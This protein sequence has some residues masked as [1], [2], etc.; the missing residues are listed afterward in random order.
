MFFFFFLANPW[1]TELL[2]QGSDWNYRCDLCLSCNTWS[3]THCVGPG[4]EPA[5]QHSRDAVD[6]LAPWQEL[7]KRFF[8]FF[9]AKKIAWKIYI[10]SSL[11]YK[12]R[13]I[14]QQNR[15]IVHTLNHIFMA[16]WFSIRVPSPFTMEKM[17]S[18]TNNAGLTGLIIWI[19][20]CKR[21]RLTPASH[22]ILKCLDR[23]SKYKS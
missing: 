4:I 22:H 19:S 16:K 11:I 13:H 23:Q 5:S 14:H 18:S 6:P 1:H 7:L 2:G 15:I 10:Q 9:M 8:F 21:M 12:D 17:V 20:T 3:L